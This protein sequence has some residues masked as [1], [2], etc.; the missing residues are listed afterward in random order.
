MKIYPSILSANEDEFIRKVEAVRPLGLRVH[1]DVMDGQFVPHKTWADPT[2]VEEITE[3][4]PFNVHLMVDDPEHAVMQWADTSADVVYFHFEATHR[5][6]LI[7]RS[8]ERH[9]NIGLAINPDT[10]VSAIGHLLDSIDAVLVMSVV[11]GASGQKFNPTALEKITELKRIRPNLWVTVDGG[12]KPHNIRRIA[13]AGAD[14][15][16]VGSALTDAEYPSL[17]L[18]ELQKNLK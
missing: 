13:A 10:P 6:E 14:A 4:M 2:V 7:I 12:V 15:V 11:P 17:A 3:E 18:A 5:H 9:E 1:I 8:T 16:V